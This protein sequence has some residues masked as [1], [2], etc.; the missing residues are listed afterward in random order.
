MT[1]RVS[2]PPSGGPHDAPEPVAV[3]PP[4]GARLL[5]PELA[6]LS[7]VVIWGLNFSV[8]K[9][10]L[11]EFP[12]LAFTAIRFFAGS[13]I[14]LLILQR[15]EGL[16]PPPRRA[17]L[18]LTV[19][20][21]LGNTLYQICFIL[22]LS[23]T[24]ATNSSLVLA[25]MPAIVTALSAALGVETVTPRIARGVGL[26]SLG[27]VLVVAMS[28]AHF[29]AATLAGDLLTLG[30]VLCWS[31]YTMGIRRLAADISPL[32]ITAWTM[33][34]GTPGLVLAGLP[35]LVEMHW[36]AV[37][38]RAWAGLAYSAIL[39]LVVAYVVFNWS[40][41]AVG[42]SRTA[43][44]TCMT[45]LVAM[46]GAFILLGERPGLTQLAGAGLIF[47]GVLLSQRR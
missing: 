9:W 40:V 27:V 31:L 42:S 18:A 11:R 43:V 26:A 19:L 16:G 24:T 15:H 12:P 38:A 7:V 17:L 29:S 32:S 10:S 13:A 28:G 21:V 23:L 46:A 39:S 33:V 41:R 14:L 5:R 22:G 6:M 36:G 3:E 1:W 45:P 44:F 2:V 4:P 37:S 34:L 8:S 30:A 35:S 25:S 47:S 20:G